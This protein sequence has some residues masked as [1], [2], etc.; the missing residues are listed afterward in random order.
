M[1]YY[2]KRKLSDKWLLVSAL[3]KSANDRLCVVFGDWGGILT[4]YV[5]VFYN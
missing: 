4:R 2:A 1:K 5:E 3:Q